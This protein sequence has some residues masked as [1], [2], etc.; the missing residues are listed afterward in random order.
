MD[1]RVLLAAM[2][3]FAGL[4]TVGAV[5]GITAWALAFFVLLAAILALLVDLRIRSD[6]VV[7]PLSLIFGLSVSS[8]GAELWQGAILELLAIAVTYLSSTVV[9]HR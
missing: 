6:V 5:W 2:I 3:A 4:Y 9:L 8:L 1:W 7:L